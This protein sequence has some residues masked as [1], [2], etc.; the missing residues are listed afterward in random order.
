MVSLSDV[1]G[2]SV[3]N[4]EPYSLARIPLRWMIRECFKTGTGIVFDARML[5][6]DVG[7][8][9]DEGIGPTAVVP[10]RLSPGVLRK[11]T[12]GELEGFSPRHIPDAIM[13]ELSSP[14][15]WIQ[16]KLSSLRLHNSKKP[17][18][19]SQ[20]PK[21]VSSKESDEDIND[22]LSPIV[23]QI[24]MHPAWNIIEWMPCKLSPLTL[25]SISAGNEL[26]RYS[27]ARQE[28]GSRGG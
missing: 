28:A 25:L 19:T 24:K 15:R 26:M 10:K 3:K 18:H 13:S 17:K 5:R 11:P 16:G 8:D 14:S 22:A 1:G 4:D 21:H 20:R 7:L 2:G 6:D 12:G 27:R 9:I 23:D